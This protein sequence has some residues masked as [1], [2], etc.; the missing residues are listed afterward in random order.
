MVHSK[1]NGHRLRLVKQMEQLG[2]V[3]ISKLKCFAHSVQS[4][5][6]RFLCLKRERRESA[7]HYKAT[8]KVGCNLPMVWLHVG[9]QAGVHA[10]SL[11]TGRAQHSCH[12]GIMQNR[13]PL[14][15]LPARS[16]G[17]S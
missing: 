15:P 11:H 2:L 13:S 16:L 9:H 6:K 3:E 1:E 8:T 10:F 5:Q 4:P 7:R 12:H 14:I 17:A